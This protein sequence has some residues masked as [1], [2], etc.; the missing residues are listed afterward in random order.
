MADSEHE[1]IDDAAHE[2]RGAAAPASFGDIERT[3][4]GDLVAESARLFFADLSNRL[5]DMDDRWKRTLAEF[6]NF[7]RRAS[8]NEAEA[9][10]RGVRDVCEAM[11]GAL[12]SLDM[13]LAQD[14]EKITARQMI[15]AV[16]T[17]RSEASKAMARHG[18][19]PIAPTVGDEFDPHLH[20]AV[21]KQPAEGVAAG[22]IALVLQAGYAMG[23][24]VLRPAKVGVAPAED[25]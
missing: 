8:T 13:A 14:P 9:R 25:E 17:I 12:D 7:Q 4:D 18:V 1:T 3:E 2:E 10:A 22:R 11:L 20:E 15:Q 21:M 16:E 19:Q 23:E 6:Q 5:A 24:R